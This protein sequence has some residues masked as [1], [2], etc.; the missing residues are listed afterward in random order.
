MVKLGIGFFGLAGVLA[1]FWSISLGFTSL[2][3]G[4]ILIV[5]G[6]KKQAQEEIEGLMA[7]IRVL[8]KE[9]Q[10]LKSKTKK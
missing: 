5:L 1:S 8:D 7:R 6:I 4:I 10:E 9:V 3:A 2:C